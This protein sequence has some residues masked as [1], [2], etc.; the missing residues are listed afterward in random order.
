MSAVIRERSCAELSAVEELERLRHQVREHPLAKVVE[1]QLADPRE[2]PRLGAGEAEERDRDQEVGDARGFDHVQVPMVDEA[3]VD[4]V[5]DQ[6][7]PGEGGAERADQRRE[8]TARS[9]R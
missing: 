5:A 4:G 3:V 8:A 6:R 7:R 9:R 2:E 1:H